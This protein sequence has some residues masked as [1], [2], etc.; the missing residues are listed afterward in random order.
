MLAGLA[1]FA[2]YP[3]IG[4][5][6]L[7]LSRSNLGKPFQAWVGASNLLK[8]LGDE[9]VRHALTVSTTYALATTI[10]AMLLGTGLALLLDRAVR[11][12]DLW[13]TLMLLPLLTPPVTVA[14]IWQLILMPKGG[15]LNA[16]AL[17]AGWIEQ[18]VTFL[19]SPQTALLFLCIA[20]VWQWT[21]FVALMVY[22]ALQTLPSDVYEAALIDGASPSRTFWSI[23]L[24]ML[25][26]ALWGIAV[27]KLVIAF[28]VFDL[29]FV[30][31]AGGPGQ[32]TTV[33]SFHI[34]RTAIQQFDIGLAA[35]Q[36][37]LFGI[38]VGVVTIPFT[39]GQARA[40]R[41]LS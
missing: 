15:L 34:Y 31:T 30:L 24:P 29:V 23:T 27:L 35:A 3:L 38:L 22:A 20:D 14:I 18:P 19:G 26:P 5:I 10:A 7:A 2:L 39:R 32:A 16:I 36:T 6:A 1:V 9:T 4:L 28:K 11:A 40:E 13:R 25:A 41:R 21:P 37:I 17:G 8:A 33:A 12:R